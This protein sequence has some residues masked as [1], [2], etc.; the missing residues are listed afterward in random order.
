MAGVI[1]QPDLAPPIRMYCAYFSRPETDPFGGDYATV[2]E[3]YHVDP[4]NSAAAP[5]PASV[6]Q[7]IYAA[8][9]QGDPTAFL[10]WHVMP[11]LTVDWYPDR[12]SLLHLV[13]HYASQMGR[14]PCRWDD[15]TFANRGDV[16]YRIALLAQWDPTDLR[17][18]PAVYVPSASMINAATAGDANLKMLGPLRSERRGG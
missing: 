14:P 7:Q 9:Q 5:T 3:P 10:L 2:L 1:C 15:E 13:S 18:A 16:T 4:L 6:A 12:I 17:L 8:S 11:G